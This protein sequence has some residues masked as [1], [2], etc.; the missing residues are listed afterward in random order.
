MALRKLLAGGGRGGRTVSRLRA[1]F[2]REERRNLDLAMRLRLGAAAVVAVWLLAQFPILS[3]LYSLAFV[4]V[5]A[6]LAF[7]QWRTHRSDRARAWHA[8]A[9][10]AAEVVLFTVALVAPSPFD[11]FQV[12][13]PMMLRG[14]PFAFFFILL[15]LAGFTYSPRLL[16]AT[17]AFIAL[18]WSGAVLWIAGLDASV[19][20]PSTDQVFAMSEQE[21][22]ALFLDPQFVDIHRLLVQLMIL[23][24]VTAIGA[25]AV[26]RQRQH[27]L[28]QIE[29]ERERA[30]LARYFSPNMVDSLATADRPLGEARSQ[31]VAVL[32]ADIVGFTGLSESL[33]P[34]ETMT[35]LRDFH[36]RMASLVFAHGG[37]LDKYIGDAVMATFG[38]PTPGPGDAV[39][40]FACALAMDSELAEWSRQRQAAGAAPVRAGI[41]LHCGP[42]LLGDI[43]D[44][45]RLEF[46]VIG[47]TVNVAAR[48]EAMTRELD[49]AI[50]ASDDLVRAARDQAGGGLAELD[51]FSVREG[52]HLRG[53]VG[54]VRIWVRGRG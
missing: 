50:V 54:V 19:L 14:E 8:Y 36:G 28:T 52:Q 25:A 48:L 5:F 26:H 13:L 39:N 16:L 4:A 24:I 47:D 49:A 46:A 43:G 20:P 34:A 29:A 45:R 32:F 41:G 53:R 15:A 18:V 22:M 23:L 17:G 10:S 33:T 40:A 44:E 21:A 30:N 35:L 31:Q 27:A 42:V 1:A 51:G 12:P 11:P 3:A 6:G 37:T 9:F 7:V 38:T 2:A